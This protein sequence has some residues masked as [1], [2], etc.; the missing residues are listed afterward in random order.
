MEG[1]ER[2]MLLRGVEKGSK[3]G[4]KKRGWEKYREAIITEEE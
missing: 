2:E 1:E 3:E 4:R